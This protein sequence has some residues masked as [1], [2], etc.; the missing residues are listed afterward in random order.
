LY[1]KGEITTVAARDSASAPDLRPA[2]PAAP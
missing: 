1:L 2:L